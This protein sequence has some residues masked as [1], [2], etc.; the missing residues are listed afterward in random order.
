MLPSGQGA[1]ATD[2]A[3]DNQPVTI[4]RYANWRLYNPG[5]GTYVSLGD[6]ADMVEDE[7]DFVIYDAQTGADITR[8]VLK[9][10]IL[11]C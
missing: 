6:L 4:K 11:E 10:I 8:A 5:T 2:M 1:G 9:Q 7:E 3:L